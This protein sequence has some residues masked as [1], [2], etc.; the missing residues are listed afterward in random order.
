MDCFGLEVKTPQQQ[1]I[2]AITGLAGGARG[3]QRTIAKG[4]D[5]EKEKGDEE[6]DM[7]KNEMQ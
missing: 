4:K 2:Q 6:E 7:I 5:K 1:L 3:V